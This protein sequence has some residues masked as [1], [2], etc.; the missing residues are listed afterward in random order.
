MDNIVNF[1]LKRP[2]IIVILTVLLFGAGIV[3]F[4]QLNIEAYPD[5]V[6]PLVKVHFGRSPASGEFTG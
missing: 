2:T 3:C 1:A 5:P 4:L 6:P